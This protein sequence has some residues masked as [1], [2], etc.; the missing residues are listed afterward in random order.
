MKEC[1]EGKIVVH[2][3]T[4]RGNH[5]IVMS[6]LWC[7]HDGGVLCRSSYIWCMFADI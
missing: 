3:A 2:D 4:G 5:R 7:L 1:A 6:L